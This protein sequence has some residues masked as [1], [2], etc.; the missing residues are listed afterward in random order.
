MNKV[1]VC[2]AAILCAVFGHPA[3][4]APGGQVAMELADVIGVTHVGGWYHFSAKD[5]LT[6]GADAIAE[7]GVHVIKLWLNDRYA[8]DY[9][10]NMEWPANLH[11][12][13]DLARTKYYR[14]VFLRPEFK[15]IV[16]EAQGFGPKNIR[17]GLSAAEAL[18]VKKECYDLTKLLLNDYKH[19][20][21]TFVLQN[22]EGDG[23]LNL[24]ALPEGERAVALQ[25]MIDWLNA[26]QDGIEQARQ[27]I[28]LQGVLVVGAAEVNHVP[29]SINAKGTSKGFDHPLMTDRVLPYTHMDL[30][31]ISAWGPC[32]TPGTEAT[33]LEKL[34]YLAS[35]A[36]PSKI[37]G[38]KNIV[39]GEF[40]APENDPVIKNQQVALAVARKQL[41]AALRWGVRYACYWQL[42]CN[43]LRPP[44]AAPQGAGGK[45]T[46][47]QFRGGWLVRPDGSRTALWTY[48]KDLCAPGNASDFRLMWKSKYAQF[49]APNTNG[50][51]R[52]PPR[53]G[54]TKLSPAAEV[55]EENDPGAVLVTA[56]SKKVQRTGEWVKSGTVLFAG[57]PTVFTRQAGATARFRLDFHGATQA[58]VSL[59]KHGDGLRYGDPRMQV[60]VLHNNK[61]ETLEVDCTQGNSGWLS[62]GTFDFAGNGS[63][64]VVI[65]RTSPDNETVSTR[66][67]AVRYKL[68]PLK[69]GAK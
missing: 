47:T 51:S 29:N 7:L 59:Y 61:T 36:P 10:F 22:W 11:S 15:T 31:S 68:M 54:S 33:L 42:Y 50:Y 18:A 52:P 1:W 44:G 67:I 27:E 41:E 17:R 28:G 62:L 8:D 49:D 5:N 20:G 65:T 32:C 34:N 46:V 12:M 2:T 37:Y 45:F 53:V 9:K 6:E 21:K 35:K 58:A 4:A 26:R 57:K 13:A 69:T 24:K 16:L 14:A 64:A 3:S 40:G 39:I 66:A 30:Y 55:S 43:G 60:T 25:G 38:R 19:T 48:F 56:D 23:H 63:D